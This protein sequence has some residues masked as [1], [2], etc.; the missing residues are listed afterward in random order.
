MKQK[1]KP[2]RQAQEVEAKRDPEHKL[3]ELARDAASGW[4]LAGKNCTRF[5]PTPRGMRARTLPKRSSACRPSRSSWPT[6]LANSSGAVLSSY[7]RDHRRDHSVPSTATGS[8]ISQCVNGRP[9]HRGQVS[10]VALNAL[11][12]E[13]RLR[14]SGKSNV[15]SQQPAHRQVAKN[16]KP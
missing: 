1:Q 16:G 12:H 11:V 7:K 14:E 2:T 13:A 4:R 6:K 5:P 10:P 8:S 15:D 9:G 3:L